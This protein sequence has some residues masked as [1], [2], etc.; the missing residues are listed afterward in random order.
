MAIRD[1]NAVGLGEL[2]G[3]LLSAVVE[4]QTAATASSLGFVREIGLEEGGDEPDRFRTVP[5]R[6]TKLDENQQPAEFVLDLPLLAMV[7]IPTLT[8]K[9]AKISFKYDVLTTTAET[10]EGETPRPTTPFPTRF[11]SQPVSLVGHVRNAPSRSSNQRSTET[12]GI[13]VEV[14]VES[15]ALPLGLERV[16]DMA[17]LATSRPATEEDE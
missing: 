11:T 7:H 16:L 14:T 10:E 1:V 8:V 13:D 2:L 12:T 9:E 17:E 3:S 15:V 5:I 6:Y 4:G